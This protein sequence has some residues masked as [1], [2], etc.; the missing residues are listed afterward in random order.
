MDVLPVKLVNAY[1]AL[2]KNGLCWFAEMHVIVGDPIDCT[3]V[4]VAMQKF[5]KF[6]EEGWKAIVAAKII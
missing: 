3:D 1:D 6:N 4:D 2:A 5:I